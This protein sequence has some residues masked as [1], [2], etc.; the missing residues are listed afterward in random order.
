MKKGAARV[1]RRLFFSRRSLQPRAAHHATNAADATRRDSAGA[2]GDVPAA[3]T[4][5]GTPTV[6]ARIAVVVADRTAANDNA[7]TKNSTEHAADATTGATAVHG[8]RGGS[9][10]RIRW[11]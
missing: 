10:T 2:V 3:R 6:G 5:V 1:E 4:P 8:A 9:G 7:T 11:H